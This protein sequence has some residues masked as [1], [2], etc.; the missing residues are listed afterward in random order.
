M[1]SINKAFPLMTDE[2]VVSILE[3]KPLQIIGEKRKRSE[4]AMDC[5]EVLCVLLDILP[6]TSKPISKELM[7]YHQPKTRESWIP[8][9]EHMREVKCVLLKEEKV[10]ISWEQRCS[11]ELVKFEREWEKECEA[12][13][14][15]F[16]DDELYD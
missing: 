2:D 14:K 8:S 9:E 4:D 11:I 16:E 12:A 6:T 5:S 10:E 3:T 1:T 7:A 13:L 15:E